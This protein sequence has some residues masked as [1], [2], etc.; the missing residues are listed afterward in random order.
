MPQY[1]SID[2]KMDRKMQLLFIT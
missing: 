1:I 2:Q